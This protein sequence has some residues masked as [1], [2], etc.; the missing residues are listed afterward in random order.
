MSTKHSITQ[1]GTGEGQGAAHGKGHLPDGDGVVT[2]IGLGT[3]HGHVAMGGVGG[4][5][6][7]GRFQ[8]AMTS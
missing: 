2:Y 6:E 5:G 3:S 7:N 4:S 8:G 1:G